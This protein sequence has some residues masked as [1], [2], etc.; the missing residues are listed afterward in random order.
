ML[1][2]EEKAAD[3]QQSHDTDKDRY[4]LKHSLSFRVDRA[5]PGLFLQ[6]G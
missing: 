1:I 2:P 5:G 3:D 6:A 4:D